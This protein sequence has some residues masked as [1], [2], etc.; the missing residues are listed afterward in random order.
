[1]DLRQVDRK[2][3]LFERENIRHVEQGEHMNRDQFLFGFFLKIFFD[4][5]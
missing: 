3:Q 4:L 2:S 5:D 1:M